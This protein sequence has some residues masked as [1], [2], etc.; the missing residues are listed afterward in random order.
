VTLAPFLY[1]AQYITAIRE[2]RASRR[3][4]VCHQVD[5]G[6]GDVLSVSYTFEQAHAFVG[7]IGFCPFFFLYDQQ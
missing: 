2:E 1:L 4:T 5:D 7:F 6:M 3:I